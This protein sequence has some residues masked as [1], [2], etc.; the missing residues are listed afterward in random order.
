MSARTPARW[1]PALILVAAL[2]AAPS[3]S[4]GK[5]PPAPS[6]QQAASSKPNPNRGPDRAR[7][8]FEDV[9]SY[10]HELERVARQHL[11][12]EEWRGFIKGMID[13]GPPVTDE[14]F[15]MIVDYLAKNFGS[16]GKEAAQ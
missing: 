1:S 13:E 3:H 16:S 15:N 2:A 6:A 4:S 10:C 12:A 5:I 11:T 9:C 8:L 7:R 14:E